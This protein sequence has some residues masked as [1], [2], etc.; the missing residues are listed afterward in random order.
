MGGNL[1]TRNKSVNNNITSATHSGGFGR[2]RNP[3][4]K[5]WQQRL[6]DVPQAR[7]YTGDAFNHDMF[8]ERN[9]MNKFG[10]NNM[11]QLKLLRD[12]NPMAT[13]DEDL[14]RLLVMSQMEKDEDSK[15]KNDEAS[16]EA[17]KNQDAYFSMK[18]AERR[19]N[20]MNNTL[21]ASVLV[22]GPSG[23]YQSERNVVEEYKNSQKRKAE[24]Q[25]EEDAYERERYGD[26]GGDFASSPLKAISLSFNEDD[27]GLSTPLKRK[28]GRYDPSS[29]TPSETRARADAR[30][31]LESAATKTIASR[32][33]PASSGQDWV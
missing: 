4:D 18:K 23:N 8:T 22:E 28:R 25:E 29:A 24:D 26:E 27:I 14:T 13:N 5:I 33:T 12:P 1:Y 31:A 11:H 17:S 3:D 10:S 32:N 16:D 20:P 21:A 15:N 7:F 9:R 30:K 2:S 19:S 6:F